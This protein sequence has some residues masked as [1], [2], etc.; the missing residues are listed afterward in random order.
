MEAGGGRIRAI[1]LPS[2]NLKLDFTVGYDY[3]DEGGYPY[4]YTGALDKN[5]EEY[6]EHIGKISYNRDCGYR[7]GLFNT[8][9]NI[10]YQGNKFIMNAVTGYQNLTDRMYLDQDFLPVDIYNIEQNNASIP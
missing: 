6:Q 1:W 10:E 9:L 4:Y 7:R 2:D 3:S 8:G 5:K